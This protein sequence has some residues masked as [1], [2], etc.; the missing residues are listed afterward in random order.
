MTL[1]IIPRIPDPTTGI[2]PNAAPGT[3]SPHDA[4][5]AAAAQFSAV[6]TVL[7]AH[8][9]AETEASSPHAVTPDAAIDDA[10]HQSLIA[11]LMTTLAANAPAVVIPSDAVTPTDPK[12]VVR[13]MDS[14]APEFRDRLE[15][16]IERMETEFGYKVDVVE[17]YRSQSR[18]DAL[19]AQ[20]RTEAGPVVTWTR[21]SN[22]TAGRAADLIIDG[23]YDDPLS[24]ERLTRIAR[25]EGLR[26]L[27]ARDP[28]H[29]E[30]PTA[31]P[32]AVSQ[33]SIG[34]NASELERPVSVIVGQPAA[35]V[36]DQG[37][38]V[39]PRQ[40]IAPLASEPELPSLT[41]AAPVQPVATMA[42]V[43]AV[44]PVAQVATVA[45]VA[46]VAA[47]GTPVAPAEQASRS[48]RADTAPVRVTQ[49]RRAANVNRE[50]AGSTPESPLIA[51]VKASQ[52]E[53][54]N[55]SNRETTDSPNDG[56]RPRVGQVSPRESANEVLRQTRDELMRAVASPDLSTS[57]SSS[58]SRDT[59]TSGIGHADMSERIARLLKVQ[60]A[61]SDRPL[62]QVL[63]RLERPDGGEDRLR[64]GLRGNTINATLDLGDQAAVDRV[65]AN[66][67]ELQRSLERQGFETDS[68]TV[69]TV[70]RSMESTTLSRAAGASAETDLQRTVGSSSTSNTNTSSRERGSRDDQQQQQQRPSPDS[71][72]Q[73]S[74]KEQ[75]GGRS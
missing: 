21:A 18:Q 16:V 72:R 39:V 20:G 38:R 6:L 4:D 56:R 45:Q 26:T 15:R 11:A 42:T 37:A 1:P 74:N 36:P 2:A 29:I 23:S 10:T 31:T 53:A 30:L 5:A 60:D 28:G 12:T 62:T 63:L 43:A 17:T 7:L 47:V 71:Q 8:D 73:R 34:P 64:V 46:Q 27:G 22:H 58:S 13:G 41:A 59:S 50:P 65:K 19:F 3:Q 67:N 44:A 9:S 51:A 32:S 14:L 69:R 24:Y 75:K 61:A 52:G 40:A 70:A 48:S 25:E 68:L 66:V 55:S 35:Q 49:G 57:S 33:S 54:S